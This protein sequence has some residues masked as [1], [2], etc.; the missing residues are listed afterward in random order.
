MELVLALP[1][2][3]EGKTEESETNKRRRK[4]LFGVF[5]QVGVQWCP[6]VSCSLMGTRAQETE[7]VGGPRLTF[8]VWQE[9]KLKFPVACTKDELN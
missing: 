1:F 6:P 5:E 8:G 2:Q 9:E 4:G 3:A 7:G